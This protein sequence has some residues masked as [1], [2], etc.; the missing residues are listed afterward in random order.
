MHQNNE[1]SIMQA[2][3][4]LLEQKI[5]ELESAREL[6][7]WGIARPSISAPERPV[8]KSGLHYLWNFLVTASYPLVYGLFRKLYSVAYRSKK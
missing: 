6:R 4:E 3:I 8:Q 5:M 1:L 2:K 7:D